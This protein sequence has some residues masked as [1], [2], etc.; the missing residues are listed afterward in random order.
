MKPTF[1][2]SYQSQKQVYCLHSSAK[3]VY[4]SGKK[5][6]YF[7]LAM[8]GPPSLV[9]KFNKVCTQFE[10]S[11]HNS[12]KNQLYTYKACKSPP[13]PHIFCDSVHNSR[14]YTH[15]ATK[16][17]LWFSHTVILHT[18]LGKS[19][20]ILTYITTAGLR[21]FTYCDSYATQDLILH[22]NFNCM[23]LR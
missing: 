20:Y 12:R 9:T 8:L 16:A 6:L 23:S 18:I 5:H 15:L 13:F 17:G 21:D 10:E 7:Y 4:N 19:S 2:A 14:L 11:Q 3:S 1:V 22:K